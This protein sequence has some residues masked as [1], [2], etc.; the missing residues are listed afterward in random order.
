VLSPDLGS[1]NSPEGAEELESSAF[2]TYSYKENLFAEFE[3]LLREQRR[4]DGLIIDLMQTGFS[5]PLDSLMKFHGYARR[6]L[7]P[8][9]AA[10]YQS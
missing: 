9:R 10:V 5:L 6:L 8:Q 4:F 7:R 3:R 2:L 1:S